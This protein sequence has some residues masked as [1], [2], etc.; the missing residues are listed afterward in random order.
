M[1]NTFHFI[2]GH[3]Q[4]HVVERDLLFGEAAA[5]RE[6]GSEGPSKH[7]AFVSGLWNQSQDWISV[8]G[9]FR[10][11]RSSRSPRS[12]LS[13][14]PL[15]WPNF[16]DV[17]EA[18]S[19]DTATPP[20]L[21]EQK[22]GGSIAPGLREKGIA[23][24][25]HDWRLAQ[26]PAAQPSPPPTFSARSRVEARWLDQGGPK[27]SG[28]DGG[29]QRLVSNCGRPASRAIDRTRS[30]Q[31]L[32]AGGLLVEGPELEACKTGFCPAV[33]SQWLSKHYPSR[34]RPTLWIHRSPR[35]FGFE[36][37]VDRSGDS[38]PIHRSRASRTEWSTRTDAQ[39]TQGR[40]DQTGFAKPP[41]SAAAHQSLAQNL[42]SCETARSTGAAT[43]GRNLPPQAVGPASDCAELSK[44][45]AGAPH[46]EQRRD[47]V[48]GKKALY[49]GGF[50]R[51]PSRPQAPGHIALESTFC[52]TSDRGI[53]GLRCRRNAPVALCSK[54]SSLLSKTV[55]GSKRTPETPRPAASWPPPP[56]PDP[57]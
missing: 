40:D 4:G 10:A 51:L 37:L 14:A 33:S 45:L 46:Q 15:S 57:Q 25:P 26:A 13:S 6:V 39:G 22:V 49:R 3:F 19:P 12:K 47:Q 27:Q 53:V 1:G 38:R 2:S 50:R 48:A 16:G 30:V 44:R 35:A 56:F 29:F 54:G 42:Q 32:P 8:E 21:G 43:A 55:R 23:G 20:K 52:E 9:T 24:C 31:P 41:F 17:G 11:R 36:C 5:V 18:N 28:L 34:Q 7:V